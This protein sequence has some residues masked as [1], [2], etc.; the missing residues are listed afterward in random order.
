MIRPTSNKTL[1][2]QTKSI[3]Q[4][5]T[6]RAQVQATLRN[7]IF[8]GQFKVGQKLVEREL[9]ELTGASRSILREVL[10]NLE[11]NG[12]IERQSYRGFSV[13]QISPWKVKEIFELRATLETL[14]AELFTE[15][16]S[17]QELADIGDVFTELE[18]SILHFE[19][20]RMR[21]AKERY[22]DILFTGCRNAEIRR[23]LENV[24]DRIYYLR[25]QSMMD[26]TRR[27]ASLTEMRHLTTALVNRDQLAARAASLAHLIGA[28]DTVL[29]LMAQD[30]AEFDKSVGS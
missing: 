28:R 3:R 24:I 8:D 20:G 23:A 18:Q 7:A 12:L 15:R 25:S 21:A 22:Y 10:V 17:A 2:P 19:L 11:A 27:A 4:D 26:P 9:C 1:P 29:N 13:T 5:T 14:A 16:A 6:L 30:A